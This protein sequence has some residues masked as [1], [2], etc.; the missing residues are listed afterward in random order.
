[1]NAHAKTA[2]FEAHLDVYEQWFEENRF[3]YLSEIEAIRKVW[4]SQG[5][6]IEIGIGSGLF[7]LPLGIA[8]GID[9]SPAM[10]A[11]AIQRGLNVT[12]AVA[13]KLP[14]RDSSIDAALMVTT[15]CFVNDPLETFHETARVLKPG[16]VLVVAFVDRNSPIGQSYL[17]HQ[18]KSLF[19]KEATF[20]C[21]Q[22]ITSLL[23][24][25]GFFISAIY[26]T[27]FT[28]IKILQTVEIPR[29]G[30]GEGSFIVIRAEKQ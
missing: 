14:Y 8:E 15:I 6:T 11:K 19:Y 28:D 9:P 25:T 7:A 18:D 23:H 5:R 24:Q 13:E 22:E 10:R 29:T 12:E 21:T 16:G 1:M 4:P 3:A 20:F 2:P 27:I 30:S 26:Q 17:Q